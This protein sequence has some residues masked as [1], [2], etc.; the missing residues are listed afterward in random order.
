VHPD[1]VYIARNPKR[2]EVLIEQ[3]RDFIA[4]LGVRPSRGTRRV[5][6]IDDAEALNIPGQNAL[7]KTLEEPPV[8]T[9]IFLVSQSERALLETVRSR[10]RPVRFGPV[11]T[12]EIA[13][14]LMARAGIPQERAGALAR[15]ARGSIGR[16]LALAEGVEPPMAELLGALTRARMIDFAEAQALAQKFFGGRDE[17]ADNFE[18]IA[19]M[20][21]EMLCSKLLAAELNAPTPEAARMMA[22]FVC[23]VDTVTMTALLALALNARAAVDS[24]ATPRLQGENWWMSAGAALRGE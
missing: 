23:T 9:V 11:P 4:R 17:A 12:A 20:L 1:F 18:L 8:H 3:V 5:A 16:A 21:E 19:R 2:T 24:M 10:M 22:E 15:L 7:L 6:I 14:V 13:A